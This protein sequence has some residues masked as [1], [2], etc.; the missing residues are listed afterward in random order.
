MKVPQPDQRR[1]RGNVR[2]G[3]RNSLT[4]LRIV[5]NYATKY[6]GGGGKYPPKLT[7]VANVQ[8]LQQAALVCSQ[9]LSLVG[10]EPP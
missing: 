8:A 2:K 3:L 6:A 9:L 4:H 7:T 1:W 10:P 5:L